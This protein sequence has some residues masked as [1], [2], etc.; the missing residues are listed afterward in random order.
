MAPKQV[1]YIAE[2]YVVK[3]VEAVEVFCQMLKFSGKST[4]P[5]V[6]QG[7]EASID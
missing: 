6:T 2:G 5:L 3:L 4:F 1:G 7:S